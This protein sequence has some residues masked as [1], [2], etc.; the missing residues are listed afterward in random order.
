MPSRAHD[1][2]LEFVVEVNGAAV[3]VTGL[4]YYRDRAHFDAGDGHALKFTAGAAADD[5]EIE[6]GQLAIPPT[7]FVFDVTDVA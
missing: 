4:N 6:M 7:H 3:E 1:R 5:H 2:I